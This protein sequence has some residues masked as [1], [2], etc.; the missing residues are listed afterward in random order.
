[1]LFISYCVV[2]V[3]N[4]RAD[5]SPSSSSQPRASPLSSRVCEKSTH[6]NG[7]SRN[8]SPLLSLSSEEDFLSVHEVITRTYLVHA[9]SDGQTV[10]EDSLSLSFPHFIGSISTPSDFPRKF[11]LS[12]GA[13][14]HAATVNIIHKC[15]ESLSLCRRDAQVFGEDVC[16]VLFSR[17]DH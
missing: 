13:I 16:S 11:C 1:M 14:F 5:I 7:T 17:S 10:S 15:T 8:F 12:F 4:S 3:L 6:T 2:Y 9:R